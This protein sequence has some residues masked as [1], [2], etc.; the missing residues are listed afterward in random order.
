MCQ[1]TECNCHQLMRDTAQHPPGFCHTSNK[2][3]GRSFTGEET[4]EQLEEYLSDLHTEVIEVK[5]LIAQLK[6]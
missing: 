3:F 2:E 1:Q 4:K 6:N 5:N